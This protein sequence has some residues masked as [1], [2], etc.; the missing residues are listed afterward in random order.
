MWASWIVSVCCSCCRCRRAVRAQRSPFPN[1]NP[2][3]S[4]GA[5]IAVNGGTGFWMTIMRENRP[6]RDTLVHE[7]FR[8]EATR[9]VG[10]QKRRRTERTTAKV[11]NTSAAAWDNSGF[12]GVSSPQEPRARERERNRRSRGRNKS[13]ASS[14]R[15]KAPWTERKSRRFSRRQDG[16]QS[17]QLHRSMHQSRVPSVEVK[18]ATGVSEV[19]CHVA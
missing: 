13:S 10:S 15:R 19:R 1:A 16:K 14:C 8:C 11:R 6:F 2:T 5:G 9:G 17:W 18:C 4:C 7:A 3:H 12:C